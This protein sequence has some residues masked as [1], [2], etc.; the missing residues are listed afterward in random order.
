MTVL[1]TAHPPAP[2][3]AHAHAQAAAELPLCHAVEAREKRQI[4]AIIAI[5]GACYFLVGSLRYAVFRAGAMDVGFFDQACYLISRGQ[6][7]FSTYI[8]LHILAD[9]AS[10]VLYLIAGLYWIYP[11]VQWLFLIQAASMAGAAWPIWRL[12]RDQN[13][14]PSI[15]RAV[16]IAYLLYPV[17]ALATMKDFYPEILVVPALLAM[18]W[19]ARKRRPVWFLFWVLLAL[20]TKEVMFL[21]IAATGFWLAT[22]QRRP[23]YGI[24]AMAL[25]IPWYFIATRIVIPH[26]TANS[27]HSNMY[28]FLDYM[29][30]NQ[31]EILQTLVVHPLVPL[32]HLLSLKTA[33]YFLIMIAPVIWGLSWRHL[34]PLIGA[35]PCLAINLL[36]NVDAFR[37]PFEHY[38]WPVV[39]FIF[40]AV[41]SALAAGAGWFKSSW[42]II[43]WTMVLVVIGVAARAREFDVD[44]AVA[45]ATGTERRKALAMINDDGGVLTTHQIATHLS[46]RKV[47]Q[48]IFYAPGNQILTLPPPE[49]IDWVLFDF[50]EDS[51]AAIEPHATELMNQYQADPHFRQIY[52]SGDIYLFHRIA[53]GA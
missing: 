23:G 19:C 26:Y 21:T 29:G 43:A 36:S 32:A 22:L 16:V 27:P 24:L 35:I 37:S 28:R 51:I 48:F 13:I 1:T 9:H 2:A 14:S 39:P 49:Q 25:A 18:V 45:G 31:N 50:H 4:A 44:Q 20:S 47:I 5:A 17:V 33:F 42:A 7:P 3:P 40:L 38:S 52:H 41:I 34:G 6:V 8:R 11:T 15:S 10:Y 12:A 46:H 53:P 30:S